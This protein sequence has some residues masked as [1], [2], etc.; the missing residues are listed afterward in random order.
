MADPYDNYITIFTVIDN[1][2][3]RIYNFNQKRKKI[4]T[5]KLYQTL[6]MFLSGVEYCHLLFSVK[7]IH[8][9]LNTS[10]EGLINQNIHLGTTRISLWI[11][12]KLRNISYLVFTCCIRKLSSLFRNR[13]QYDSLR[14]TGRDYSRPGK[15]F[16]T[17]CT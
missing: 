2:F 3:W 9:S 8:P 4:V 13:N 5:A 11:F 17:I 15:Y 7:K 14:Y 1:N 16:V 6:M 10:K 12:S